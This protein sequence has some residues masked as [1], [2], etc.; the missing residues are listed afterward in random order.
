MFLS[1]KKPATPFS[2]CQPKLGETDRVRVFEKPGLEYKFNMTHVRNAGEYEIPQY[3]TRFSYSK[4]E[5]FNGYGL[6][7]QSSRLNVY[8]SKDMLP[9]STEGMAPP[10][11]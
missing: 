10:G 7:S 4:G 3:F 11:F 1:V 9:N 5:F 8:P 2:K 6:G